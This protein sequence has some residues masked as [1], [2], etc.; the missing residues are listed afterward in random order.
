MFGLAL[1][2]SHIQA[3]FRIDFGQ[4]T[5]DRIDAVDGIGELTSDL[6]CFALLCLGFAKMMLMIEYN[7]QFR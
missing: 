5:W 1:G 3:N 4:A 6:T 7:I 2:V